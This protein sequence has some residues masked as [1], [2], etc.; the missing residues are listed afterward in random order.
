MRHRPTVN[1][2]GR[3][4]VPLTVDAVLKLALIL[5]GVKVAFRVPDESVAILTLRPLNSGNDPLSV[6]AHWFLGWAFLNADRSDEAIQQLS[7]AVELDP[8]S[9]WART[10]LER[11][12]HFKSRRGDTPVACVAGW[13]ARATQSRSAPSQATRVSPL[14]RGRASPSG[15]MHDT[16]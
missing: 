3:E 15:K 14:R 9:A 4:P 7:K 5:G 8:N 11:V 13:Q 2:R 10:F 1:W 12:M 16:L 6:T